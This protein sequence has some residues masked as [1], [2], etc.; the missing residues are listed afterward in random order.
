MIIATAGHVDHGKTAL[1]HALTGT[2]ADRLPEEKKR[3]MT[4]DLGYAYLPTPDG[5]A[6]GF[7]D[8]PGHERF[9]GNMLA[10]VGGVRHALLV[11]AADDGVMPQTRE[12]LAILQLLRLDSLTVVV[13]KSDL[14]GPEA[15]ERAMAAARRTLAEH[16]L[17]AAALLPVSARTGAGVDALRRHLLQLRDEAVGTERR[18]RLAIDR[19]FTI[20]GAGLVVTGTAWSGRVG[21][22]DALWLSGRDAA[23]R[24]RGLHVQNQPAREGQAGQRIA[25]N[26]AGDVD[27]QQI[28]RGD[29]LLA[30]A[31]PEPAARVSVRLRLAPALHAALCHWQAV[32]VHHAASHCTG[33][34]ALLER[35]QLHPGDEGLAELSLDRPLHLADGDRLILRDAGAQHTLACATVLERQPP[36]RGKRHEDRLAHLRALAAAGADDAENLRLRLGRQAVSLTELAWDR[37][38]SEA[39]LERLLRATPLRVAGQH[40]YAPEHWAD[41]Q[42]QLLERLAALH[43]QQPDQLGA[44]R[45]RARRLALPQESEAAVN[46]MIDQLLAEGRLA[47]TRGWLHLPGHVLAF[48]AEEA[49]LWRRLEPAFAEAN[50]APWVREL[51]ATAGVEEEAARALLRK[52]ARLGHVHAVVRDRYLSSAAIRDMAAG[53]RQL[54]QD[55]GYADAANFRDQLGCGR[56]LAIQI[57]EYFDRCGFTRRL[58]DRHLLR[59]ARLFD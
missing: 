30:Q 50:Q 39:G 57:L 28:Q 44:S 42:S 55:A 17:Q 9:L 58:G 16:S 18:F 54:N 41:L 12:H 8:V 35:P 21:V 20:S 47:N 43:L 2:D 38:L 53:V 26:L 25:L 27:K 33:R 1:L 3:G 7:I 14:A 48:D 34:V 15:L 49:A 19:A 5:G 36:T 32:H 22:G 29:W 52:A 56:K 11:I 45:G 23:V 24:V 59:E 46:L 40:A 6:I 10:G 37:Q 13:S 31:A 4:I 51:A